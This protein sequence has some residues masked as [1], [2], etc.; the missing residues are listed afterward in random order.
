[1]AE[2]D[3]LLLVQDDAKGAYFDE[4]PYPLQEAMIRLF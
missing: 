4:A 3:A 2:Q 1:V